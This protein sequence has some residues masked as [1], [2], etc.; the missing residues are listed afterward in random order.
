MTQK[1]IVLELPPGEHGALQRRLA[2][3]EFEFRSVP[4]AVFSAKGP[5]V[6][7]TLYRSGKLVVQGSEPEA[8]VARFTDLDLP[9][10]SVGRATGRADVPIDGLPTGVPVIGSD[11]TGK[12]DYFGPLVAAAVL[13]EPEQE[14]MLREWGVADSKQ[15]SDER[16]MRLGALLR[17]R[18]P[19]AIETLDPPEYN[20]RYPVFRSLNP[21]LADLHSR[22]IRAL[23]ESSDASVPHVLVD[24]FASESLMRKALAGVRA[25]LHQAH[26]AE[27][28]AAVAA[29]SILAR[30]EFLVRLKELSEQE[31]VVL[32]KGAGAPVDAAGRELVAIHGERA[33]GRVAKL[34]FKNTAKVTR[35]RR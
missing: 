30:Q 26:R 28:H 6:I 32:H 24:Q 2:G 12:G 27:R 31:G 29:A 25:Q 20:E 21:M 17:E 4:H 13:V 11:E 5:G 34:H 18:V 35:G 14:Q 15:L 8:F 9:S 22:A 33:L 16:A 7:A 23:V 1:T 19:Y 3:G 10:T